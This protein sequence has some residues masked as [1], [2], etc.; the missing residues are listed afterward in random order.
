MQDR[1]VNPLCSRYAGQRMQEIFSN[2]RK[3]VTWRRL[4]LALAEA[5]Q[6]LGI[7]ITDLQLQ[8]MRDH[9]EEIDCLLSVNMVKEHENN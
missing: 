2:D 1:Y 3:F 4:W 5:E 8:E 6:E 9:L 7:P